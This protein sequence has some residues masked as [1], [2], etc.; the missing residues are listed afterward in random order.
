MGAEDLCLDLND[1]M[2]VSQRSHRDCSRRRAE[3]ERRMNVLTVDLGFLVEVV[4]C[5]VLYK[6][7]LPDA[8]NTD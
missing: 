1:C 8:F 5:H 2:M 3:A 6:C 7:C 4:G